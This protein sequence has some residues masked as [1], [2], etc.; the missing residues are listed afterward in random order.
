MIGHSLSN[1][2]KQKPDKNIPPPRSDVNHRERRKKVISKYVP[3][4]RPDDEGNRSIQNNAESSKRINDK[5]GEQENFEAEKAV[6]NHE[7]EVNYQLLNPEVR[8]G[9]D[10]PKSDQHV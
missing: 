9:A 3:K 4:S 2:R 6:F 10:S 8:Y 1:C 7:P 5:E